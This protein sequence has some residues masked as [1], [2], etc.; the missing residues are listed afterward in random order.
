LARTGRPAIGMF[1]DLAAHLNIR[2]RCD[3][4]SQRI[5]PLGAGRVAT[6]IPILASRRPAES[7]QPVSFSRAPGFRHSIR[8]PR[9][10]F[11]RPN[12]SA[13]SLPPAAPSESHARFASTLASL[14]RLAEIPTMGFLKRFF[15]NVFRDGHPHTAPSSFE[16]LSEEQLE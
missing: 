11:E 15:K 2:G 1:L 14:L 4:G 3:R 9:N 10:V 13:R 6:V 8:A 7:R 5:G 12:S 16:N